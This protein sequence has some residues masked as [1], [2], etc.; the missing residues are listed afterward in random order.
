MQIALAAVFLNCRAIIR[1]PKVR[2]AAVKIQICRGFVVDLD[3]RAFASP[4]HADGNAV[5]KNMR[6]DAFECRFLY[7]DFISGHKP[8]FRAVDPIGF[9]VL[10]DNVSAHF[11]DVDLLIELGRN[12]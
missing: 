5:D 6:I 3:R 4:V 11:T 10:D 2:I 8:A 7:F 12:I 9:T 1:A